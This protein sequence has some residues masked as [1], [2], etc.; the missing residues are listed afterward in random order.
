MG[1][2][3]RSGWGRAQPPWRKRRDARGDSRARCRAERGT[4]VAPP[5]KPVPT[6]SARPRP[7]D[8]R[9]LTV[10]RE[11]AA[12]TSTSPASTTPN[13]AAR[14]SSAA[15][16]RRRLRRRG[17][18]LGGDRRRAGREAPEHLRVE[19]GPASVFRGLR[20]RTRQERSMP[21]LVADASRQVP[22]HE[23]PALASPEHSRGGSVSAADRDLVRQD[24][25]VVTVPRTRTPRRSPPKAAPESRAPSCRP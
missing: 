17:R 9:S 8:A 24:S 16:R 14:V 1:V 11:R 22:C 25:S 15:A 23:E 21:E 5:A 18:T 7:H 13:G 3:A 12:R 20:T 19:A 6:Q 4:P 2:S 10:R